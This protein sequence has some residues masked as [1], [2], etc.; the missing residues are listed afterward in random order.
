LDRSS[1]VAGS[2]HPALLK[3]ISSNAGGAQEKNLENSGIKFAV[4][5]RSS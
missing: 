3:T 2:P 1:C 4:R 5:M